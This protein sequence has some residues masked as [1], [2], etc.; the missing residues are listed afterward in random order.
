MK[1]VFDRKHQVSSDRFSITVQFLPPLTEFL[2][3]IVREA[4]TPDAFVPIEAITAWSY[5][6]M[7]A[8]MIVLAIPAAAVYIIGAHKARDWMQ[9]PAVRKGTDIVTGLVMTAIAV[10]LLLR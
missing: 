5:A 10:I 2:N 3:W 4:V 6:A 1:W 9:T 7:V 8:I